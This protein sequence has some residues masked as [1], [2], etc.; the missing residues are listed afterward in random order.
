MSIVIDE[1]NVY[2]DPVSLGVKYLLNRSPDAVKEKFLSV[3]G[4]APSWISNYWM[5]V[6]EDLSLPYGW[7]RL[8]NLFS[9]ISTGYTIIGAAQ[10]GRLLLSYKPLKGGN[11]VKA[12]RT[13]LMAHVIYYVLEISLTRI[14]EVRSC[15]VHHVISILLFLVIRRTPTFYIVVCALPKYVHALAWTMNDAEEDF[16]LLAYNVANYMCLLICYIVM[17]LKSGDYIRSIIDIKPLVHLTLVTTSLT[18]VNAY[19]YCALY[20][21][22]KCGKLNNSRYLGFNE[23]TIILTLCSLLVAMVITTWITIPAKR[24]SIIIPRARGKKAKDKKIK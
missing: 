10:E 16:L 5:H 3:I 4:R 21:T 17:A 18:L 7:A 15:F 14:Y 11:W 6:T 9:L 19:T 22:T 12:Y 20:S 2:S 24:G 1:Y 23:F 8:F 13:Y